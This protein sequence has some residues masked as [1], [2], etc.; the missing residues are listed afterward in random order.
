MVVFESLKIN[1]S[2]CPL[3]ALVKFVIDVGLEFAIAM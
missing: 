1:V 2:I 3:T